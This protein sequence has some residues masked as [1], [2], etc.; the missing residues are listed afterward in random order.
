MNENADRLRED[1]LMFFDGRRQVYPLYE[2]LE[3]RLLRQHPETVLRVS[4]TQ[5]S[6]YDRRMYACVSF[7]RPRRKAEMPESWFT[8]TLGLPYPLASERVAART[9][10]YPGRWTTHIVLSRPEELDGELFEWVR[11]ADEFARTK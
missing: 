8:L 9:E 1:I 3:A 10:P 5:I 6:F 4:K 2:A 11:Q 7:L